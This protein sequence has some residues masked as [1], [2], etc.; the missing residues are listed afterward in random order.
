MSVV[1]ISETK[2]RIHPKKF[3]LWISFASIVMMFT[4]LTSAYVVRQAQG[5]WHE[6]RIPHIFFYSTGIILLSSV[7]LHASYLAFK[8]G[9]E[10]GYK[11]LLVAASL[12]GFLFIVVQYMG[13][14][15]L[16]SI[17]VYINGNP[18]D[19]FMF[20]IPGIHAAHV[21]GGLG[22]L[23]VALVHAFVLPYKV[24]PKRLL[25]FELTLHY[26]HFVDALWIYLIV[27]FILAQS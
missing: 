9:N 18:A 4:G 6:F 19:S 13:W 12:L 22:A 21:L 11:A 1:A 27:F 16:T 10:M 15:Q 24:T 2:Q 26:W 23:T 14:Q 8:K 5:N 7:A 25:R 3:A 20:V 17:G